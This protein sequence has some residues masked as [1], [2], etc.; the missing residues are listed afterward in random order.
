MHAATVMV[1]MVASYPSRSH[2]PEQA[3]T[4][5]D[6]L[7]CQKGPSLGTNFTLACPYTI[8]AHYLELEWTSSW[9]VEPDL[10]RISVGLEEAGDL[11]GRFERALKAAEAA[12]PVGKASA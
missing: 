4:F 1:D 7:E 2:H 6:Q 8:L 9:G 5:F 12:T 11:T 10:V 3:V